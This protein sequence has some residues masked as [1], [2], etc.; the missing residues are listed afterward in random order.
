MIYFDL[1]LVAFVAAYVSELSGFMDTLK[2][3]VGRWL[4]RPVRRLRPLDCPLCLAWWCCLVYA[5]A[6]G[7]V[8]VSTVAYI[9]LLSLMCRPLC[10]IVR[11]ALEGLLALCR[12]LCGKMEE[13]R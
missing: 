5:V 12:L 1:F 13:W 8:S 2:D 7:A 11:L 9:A 4:G 6:R 3:V 10:E